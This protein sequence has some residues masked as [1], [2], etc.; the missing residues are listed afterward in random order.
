MRD[1][2]DA[3]VVAMCIGI[4]D[5]RRSIDE[6]DRRDQEQYAGADL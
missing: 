4:G 1:V 3:F 2:C 6:T 5:L